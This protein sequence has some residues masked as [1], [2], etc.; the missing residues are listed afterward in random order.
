[1]TGTRAL[2]AATML[3]VAGCSAVGRPPIDVPDGME[4]DPATGLRSDVLEIDAREIS[5]QTGR[6]F[7]QVLAHL[8]AQQRLDPIL[9]D[10][11]ARFPS[12]VAAIWTDEGRLIAQFAGEVDGVAV[13]RLEEAD[14]EVLP[15]LV[16]FTR[17][18]LE[19]RQASVVA[20][21]ASLGAADFGVATDTA[22]QR[23]LVSV[24]DASGLTEAAIRAA[25]PAD[26]AQHDVSID[27]VEGPVY[28]EWSAA[29][30]D[31]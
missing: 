4:W 10:V 17:P 6:P 7:E 14:I 3:V 18:E 26:V 2:I 15:V 25:L 21:L 16:R 19:S 22:T 20:T 8:R 31:R 23:I 27:I 13:A 28:T 30:D 12:F 11:E 9:A 24:S 29:H 5:R 1:M